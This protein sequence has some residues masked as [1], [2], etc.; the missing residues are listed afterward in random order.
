MTQI[1]R[2]LHLLLFILHQNE[3]KSKI[4]VKNVQYFQYLKC[5]VK[6]HTVCIKSTLSVELNFF[7]RGGGE[8]SVAVMNYNTK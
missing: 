1:C 3:L 5:H 4:V 6:C 8:M 7:V 2:I